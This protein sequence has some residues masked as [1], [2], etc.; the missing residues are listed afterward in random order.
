MSAPARLW[1]AKGIDRVSALLDGMGPA[2]PALPRR[3]TPSA[4]GPAVSLDLGAA[5]RYVLGRRT[6]EGGYCFYRTPRWGVEEP[7]AADT[8]AALESLRILRLDPPDPEVTGRWLRGLQTQ[9]GRFPTLTIG[10]AVLRALDVLG[11]QPDRSPR[12]WVDG[13]AARLLGQ[14]GPRDWRLAL[15]DLLHVMELLR[16]SGREPGDGQRAAISRIL[17]AARD[18]LGGWA[19]PGGDLETTAVAVR[20]ARLAGLPR[21]ADAGTEGFVDRCQDRTLGLRVRP[22]AATTSA[23]ALWGGLALARSLGVPVSYPVAVAESLALLQ[24]PDGG[25]GPRHRAIATLRDTWLGLRAARLLEES[26]EDG[27]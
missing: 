20:L 23:G 8:L 17:A 12:P 25:L 9:D 10:W 19:R 1:R 21:R 15:V 13:W 27:S 2:G 24:R 5:G 3:L 16:L 22:G 18:P 4:Q 14:A 7:N 6:P 11:V 26:K